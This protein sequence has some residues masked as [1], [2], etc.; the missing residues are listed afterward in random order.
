MPDNAEDP[1]RL[2]NLV[3]EVRNRLR[4]EV[5]KRP[6]TKTL[7][8]LER[9]VDSVDHDRNQDGLALFA[10]ETVSRIFRTRFPLT[11]RAAVDDCFSLR[12]LMRA[13]RRAEPYALLVLSLKG[14]RLFEGS[15]DKLFEVVGNGFPAENGSVGGGSQ[16]P[17]GPGVNATALVDDSRARFVRSVLQSAEGLEALPTTLIVA[18]TEE[19]LAEAQAADLGKLQIA[20]TLPGNYERENTAKLGELAFPVLR[21]ARRD[22][23][24]RHLER[25]EVARSA[26]LYAEGAE[27]IAT[28][29]H[30]GRVGTLVCGFDYEIAGRYNKDTR[31]LELLSA[32]ES[33]SDLDDAVEWIVA[34]TLAKGG[35]VRFAHDEMLGDTPLVAILR[36]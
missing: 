16:I 3:S 2:K 15:L 36:Y 28:L 4:N 12:G 19:I 22:A 10:S 21:Q 23:T 29:A 7:E 8:N 1:I 24:A 31:Q 34:E 14:A 17:S 27:T 30:D 5:G 11:E 25:L 26:G 32:P 6:A 13:E 20:G 9:A 33:W 18:G 35:E